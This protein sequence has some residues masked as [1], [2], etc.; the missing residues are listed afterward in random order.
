MVEILLFLG[1][2]LLGC[3]EL[4]LVSTLVLILV[5]LVSKLEKVLE[6]LTLASTFTY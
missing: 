1:D 4:L 3:C 6:L 5:V 2:L